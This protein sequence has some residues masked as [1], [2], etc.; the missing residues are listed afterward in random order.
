M[1]RF[2]NV[3]SKDSSQPP[4]TSDSYSHHVVHHHLQTC[5]VGR[6][7]LEVHPPAL[8]S[9]QDRISCPFRLIPSPG[10]QTDIA[11]CRMCKSGR[12]VAR[13]VKA[14]CS[15]ESMQDNWQASLL[16]LLPFG[17]QQTNEVQPDDCRMSTKQ[18][19]IPLCGMYGDLQMLGWLQCGESSVRNPWRCQKD[20]VLRLVSSEQKNKNAEER[21]MSYGKAHYI[22]RTWSSKGNVIIG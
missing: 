1:N 12:W 14:I 16:A 4:R 15:R 13:W 5:W 8:F 21:S 11:D 19:R 17:K 22:D 6:G 3:L 2:I 18:A 7:Y 9:T 10:R 20:V